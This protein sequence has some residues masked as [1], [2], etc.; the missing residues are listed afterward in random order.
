MNWKVT[1]PW[2]LSMTD[3]SSG[4]GRHRT[5]WQRRFALLERAHHAHKPTALLPIVLVAIAMLPAI[6]LTSR[7]IVADEVKPTIAR[8][9]IS[10]PVRKRDL[11]T[12][13]ARQR[14]YQVVVTAGQWKSIE[15]PL[16][17][18]FG[19]EAKHDG[20]KVKT[21]HDGKLSL[22]A[23][24]TGTYS[25][26]SAKGNVTVVAVVDATTVRTKLIQEGFSGVH[27]APTVDGITLSGS[28]KN[29]K[30]VDRCETIAKES[31]A[32]VQNEIGV[33]APILVESE[34]I[35][36]AVNDNDSAQRL[37]EEAAGPKHNGLAGGYALVL[38]GADARTQ[39]KAKLES[40]GKAETISAPK[41]ITQS[42]R[43]ASVE[44][45]VEVPILTRGKDSVS[46]D[47]GTLTH[48]IDLVPTSLR[49]GGYRLKCRPSIVQLDEASSVTID[50]KKVPGRRTRWLDTV[51]KLSSN[52]YLVTVL[53]TSDSEDEKQ[54]YLLTISHV[55]E[56]DLVVQGH[57]LATEPDSDSR[58]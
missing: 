12:N 37:F 24:K 39:F 28:V 52:D 8:E 22:L 26:D 46:V 18:H 29:E 58:R 16:A 27:V 33:G 1:E 17:M 44:I 15:S 4:G 13:K 32:N 34:M 30:D 48:R 56:V 42:G 5:F 14:G 53:K 38:K 36:L 9:A 25:I 54:R 31:F 40:F 35:Q 55:K 21:D 23:A 3:D 10:S 47:Y 20:I 41:V 50:G 43:S 2:T 45:G 57:L 6:Q 51:V 7:K 19:S 11:R 49:Q